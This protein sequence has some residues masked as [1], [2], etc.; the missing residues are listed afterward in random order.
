MPKP[1]SGRMLSVVACPRDKGRLE[2]T[3]RGFQSRPVA[4]SVP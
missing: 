2:A 1:P 4:L 3:D